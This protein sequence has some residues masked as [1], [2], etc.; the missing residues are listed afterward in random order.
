M[1]EAEA[2]PVAAGLAP[3]PILAIVEKAD[4]PALVRLR[5]PAQVAVSNAVVAASAASSGSAV[6]LAGEHLA[7]SDLLAEVVA[8]ESDD[9]VEERLAPAAK[10]RSLKKQKTIFSYF[11]RNDAKS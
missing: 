11:R 9:A 6:V 3:T 8:V 2:P 10:E 1:V 4:V 5:E 7:L